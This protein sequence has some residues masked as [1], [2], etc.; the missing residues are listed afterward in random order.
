MTGRNS[1]TEY[2]I[3]RPGV[4]KKRV[5]CTICEN[6]THSTENCIFRDKEEFAK[7][8]EEADQVEELTPE[9]EVEVLNEMDSKG[10]EYNGVR[11]TITGVM[12][13]MVAQGNDEGAELLE[14]M[15]KVSK[16]TKRYLELAKKKSNHKKPR[17]EEK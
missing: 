12:K 3:V 9:N 16:Q 7:L 5:Y 8:L 6:D 4:K 10:L 17:S 13:I 15:D 2:Y 11:R 14:E 1:S